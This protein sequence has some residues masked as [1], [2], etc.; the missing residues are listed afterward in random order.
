MCGI[1]GVVF[2]KD[3]ALSAEFAGRVMEK[4]YRFSQTRGSEAAWREDAAAAHPAT[5]DAAR[6]T[7]A[8]A[9]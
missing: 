3:P 4:L 9:P 6:V 8:S 2:G 5:G 1:F 7:S